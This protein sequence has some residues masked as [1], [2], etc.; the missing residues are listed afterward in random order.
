MSVSVFVSEAQ[1]LLLSSIGF[2][3]L[4]LLLC[5][6]LLL[7]V[8]SIVVVLLS[9]SSTVVGVVADES[10]ATEV[11]AAAEAEVAKDSIPSTCESAPRSREGEWGEAM[12]LG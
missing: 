3:M 8:C 12:A 6:M 4:L 11:A 5:F 9:L 2:A 10:A 1:F 7:L